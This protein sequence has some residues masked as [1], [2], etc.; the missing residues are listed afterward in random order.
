MVIAR[1]AMPKSLLT[2]QRMEGGSRRAMTMGG[3][4]AA[5]EAETTYDLPMAIGETEFSNGGC[6]RVAQEEEGRCRVSRCEVASAANR[7][8]I[9]DDGVAAGSLDQ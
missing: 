7:W 3:H 8:W 1:Q 5:E 4:A 9:A 6:R 2:P